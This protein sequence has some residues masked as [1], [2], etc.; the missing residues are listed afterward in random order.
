MTKVRNKSECVF[1]NQ[2][3]RQRIRGKREIG[4][5]SD[6][7]FAENVLRRKGEIMVFYR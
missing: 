7:G 5:E 6:I 4:S 3:V 1:E 2:A